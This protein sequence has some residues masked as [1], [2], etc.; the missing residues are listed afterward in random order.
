VNS[1]LTKRRNGITIKLAGPRRSQKCQ[2]TRYYQMWPRSRHRSG[3]TSSRGRWLRLRRRRFDRRRLQVSQLIIPCTGTRL[4]RGGL[5]C[6]LPNAQTQTFKLHIYTTNHTTRG[7]SK[8]VWKIAITSWNR[9]NSRIRKQQNKCAIRWW[10]GLRNE[11]GKRRST[12][13]GQKGI[14]LPRVLKTVR[15]PFLAQLPPGPDQWLW[16]APKNS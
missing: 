14:N 7:T 6:L 3:W 16:I 13:D 5:G 8:S 10:R 2:P 9:K 4:L 12:S 11:R 1:C 15:M